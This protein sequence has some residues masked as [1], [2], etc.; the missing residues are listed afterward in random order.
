MRD[1]VVRERRRGGGEGVCVTVS[2]RAARGGG[3]RG[4]GGEWKWGGGGG[5]GW[6]GGVIGTAGERQQW[7]KITESTISVMKPSRKQTIRS[8]HP[9]THTRV[10]TRL[11]SHV[12]K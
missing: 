5:V 10:F 4:R 2:V 7:R 9:P 6:G 12:E 1:R 3:G 11:I 8:P